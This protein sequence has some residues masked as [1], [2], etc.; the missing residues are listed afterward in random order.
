MLR[1]SEVSFCTLMLLTSGLACMPVAFDSWIGVFRC[2]ALIQS[3]AWHE[4]TPVMNVA[5]SK[6]PSPKASLSSSTPHV[7]ELGRIKNTIVAPRTAQLLS[8]RE[9]KCWFKSR[10]EK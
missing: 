3:I 2:N 1:T 10:W 8:L 5:R 6:A 9:E 7:P 4:I